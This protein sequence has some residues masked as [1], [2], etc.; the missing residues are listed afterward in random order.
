MKIKVCLSVVAD[1]RSREK[2]SQ[3]LVHAA[4]K[5]FDQDGRD[6]LKNLFHKI[7][8]GLSYFPI[9]CLQWQSLFRK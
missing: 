6:V 4:A 2:A 8:F 9:F 1:P 7:Y 5:G 3:D